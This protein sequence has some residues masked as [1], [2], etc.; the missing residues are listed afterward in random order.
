MK[1][2][3]HSLLQGI[4]NNI[5][6]Y[7]DYTKVQNTRKNGKKLESGDFNFNE[8]LQRLGDAKAAANEYLAWCEKNGYTPKFDAFADHENYYKL[9]EDFSCYDTDGATNTPLSAVQ[10]NFPTAEDAFG[11]MQDLIREGLEEDTLL[12]ANMDRAV[13]DIVKQIQAVLPGFEQSVKQGKKKSAAKAT[14]VQAERPAAYSREDVGEYTRYQKNITMDDVRALRKING[15]KEIS[16]NLFTE[17]DLQKTQK[18]AYKYYQML[19]AKSPFFRAW[20]GEWRANEQTPVKIV[21]IPHITQEEFD[22][23]VRS[24]VDAGD[25]EILDTKIEDAPGWQVSLG[26]NAAKNTE[27]HAGHEKKS[28]VG[29][30]GIRALVKHGVLL[31]TEVHEFHATTKKKDPNNDPGAFNHRFYALGMEEDG[32]I[33]IYRVNVLDQ[34]QGKDNQNDFLFHN[35][36]QIEVIATDIARGQAYNKV[37]ASADG[38]SEL[39]N[40]LVATVYGS[41]ATTEFTVADLY[42]LVKIFDSKDFNVNPH[43]NLDPSLLNADGTPKLVDGM[44]TN[45]AGQQKAYDNIGTFDR[46]NANPRFSR[47]DVGDFGSKADIDAEIE[48]I[49]DQIRDIQNAKWQADDAAKKDPRV[50]E[51]E[52]KMWAAEDEKGWSGSLRERLDYKQTLKLVKEELAAEIPEGDLNE[53]AQRINDLKELRENFLKVTPITAEQYDMLADHFGTTTDYAVAGFILKDGR[54]LDFSGKKQ[55]GK[56]YSGGREVYHNEVGDVLNLPTDTSPRIDMVSNGNIR[57]VPE[58]NGINLSQRPT[59]KQKAAIRGFIEYHNGN[60]NIDI[61]NTAGRTI[62]TFAYY[63]GT[64]ASKILADIDTYFKT[65]EKPAPVSIYRQFFSREDVKP[66]ELQQKLKESE[67]ARARVERAL[68]VAKQQAEYWRSEFDK[69]G[70]KGIYRANPSD[71]RKFANAI[72][73]EYQWTT[74]KASDIAERLTQIAEGFMNQQDTADLYN[75]AL[76]IANEIIDNSFVRI[77]NEMNIRGLDGKTDADWIKEHLKGTSGYVYIAKQDQAD[78][79]SQ[80]GEDYGN[81]RKRWLKYGIRLTS[82]IGTAA[83]KG[84]LRT[85]DSLYNE[86]ASLY[87]L[88]ENVYTISEMV[89]ILDAAMTEDLV[90]PY[91][92]SRSELSWSDWDYVTE[93]AETI[94]EGAISGEVRQYWTRAELAERRADMEK[95]RLGNR[96]AETR[97]ALQEAKE[98]G[99]LDKNRSA[100]YVHTVEQRC[101]SGF[102]HPDGRFSFFSER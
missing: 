66:E 1:T 97:E 8:A 30:T 36:K 16:V 58:V 65:G 93:L 96:L 6:K 60:V 3:M 98:Q 57:L 85:I 27:H 68:R 99:R 11:S 45:Y 40:K 38:L 39:V 69:P 29:M 74:V 34:Y 49:Q 64:S 63:N 18:W 20:F 55:Y 17:D 13:P 70:K 2:R 42:R 4:M 47:E 89:E 90:N 7:R 59:A 76:E 23:F 87:G 67:A 12:Q 21:D 28:K 48:R 61:D 5:D 43:D 73:A 101:S 62:E 91:Y 41:H 100:V 83:R 14:Q 80:L 72:L 82:E 50:Q 25:V 102:P 33:N 19:G 81:F 79:A 24:Q 22:E 78:I 71:I 75:I 51:A 9:L 92:D 77:D 37:A 26:I 95:A 54:M 52:K 84:S 53:L 86:I 35:L 31:D 32:S 46:E 88:K 94:Y 10:L 56:D 44:Y 15:G